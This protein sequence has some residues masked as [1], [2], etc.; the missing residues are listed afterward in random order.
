MSNPPSLHFLFVKTRLA[1]PRSSG[2]DVHSYYMMKAL[3]ELGHQVSLLTVDRPS[4][5]AVDGLPL[6]SRAVFDEL[7]SES[8]TTGELNRLQRRFCSYW[9]VQEEHIIQVGRLAGDLGVD[10]VVVVGL[11]VLPYLAAVKNAKRIWYAAD[12]WLWHHL[13]QIFLRRPSTLSELK[14]AIVKGGYEWAFAKCT[15][16]VWVVSD[17]DRRA[18]RLVMRGVCAD[19][20]PNGVDTEHFS[21]REATSIPQS[22]TFW[23]RLDF[24]PNI[25]AVRWFAEN[26]WPDLKAECGEARFDVFGFAPTE[27]VRNLSEQNGFS[28]SANIPDLRQE[29][30]RR[31]LVILPFVSGGGMKNKFLEAAALAKPIVASPRALN[32]VKLPSQPV[33]KVASRPD[34]WVKQ[35]RGL[36][37]EMETANA[38]GRHARAWIRAEYSWKRA[39][40]TAVEGFR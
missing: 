39:A 36:W 32:G 28:I 31:Q 26:V 5:E 9:G 10:A 6:Q 24:G 1:F 20:I 33:L 8:A 12:E 13:S 25:D 35:I 27:A 34:E 3:T 14:P 40:K 2:H 19:T 7:P 17:S 38:M 15:D 16:H 11:E 37:D 30:A 18:V 22:C 23:G 4:R 29:I 21:P